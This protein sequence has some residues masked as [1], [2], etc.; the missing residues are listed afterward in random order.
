MK[1]STYYIDTY[2]L[3]PFKTRISV[4]RF[5][6]SDVELITVATLVTLT[7]RTNGRGLN[8]T[9]D[10][11]VSP[12]DG[13]TVVSAGAQ[14]GEVVGLTPGKKYT[15]TISSIIRAYSVYGETDA[16]V[17][18]VVDTS[19]FSLSVFNT[20]AYTLCSPNFRLL[21]ST[22]ALFRFRS[23][24]LFNLIIQATV[25]DISFLPTPII[26]YAY[27][28]PSS[29]FLSHSCDSCFTLFLRFSLCLFVY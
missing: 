12:T 5:K 26:S 19:K 24:N 15:M 17:E 8:V 28:L 2:V 7:W 29:S 6:I 3:T 11:A 23:N 14:G 22:T 10:L 25:D 1:T 20:K 27:F 16:K 9:Y 18:I 21:I 4:S 13:A